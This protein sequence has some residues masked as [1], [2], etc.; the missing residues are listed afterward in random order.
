[1]RGLRPDLILK[2]PALEVCTA[3]VGDP[4]D[5]VRVDILVDGAWGCEWYEVVASLPDQLR[6]LV[7]LESLGAREVDGAEHCGQG[8]TTRVSGP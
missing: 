1:M 5:E 6:E 7:A 8:P 3:A 4:Q 2:E